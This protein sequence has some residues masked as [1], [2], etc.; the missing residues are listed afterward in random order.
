ME[1][2]TN[3]KGGRTLLNEGYIYFVDRESADKVIWRCRNKKSCRA[4]LHTLEGA[5]VKRLGEHTHA[6]SGADIEVV[7]VTSAIRQRAEST[8]D[9]PAQ[10]ITGSIGE[11][12]Q[13]ASA[14]L[15]SLDALRQK[16]KHVRHENIDTPPN[17]TSLQEIVVPPA[18][19]TT[20]NGKFFAKILLMFVLFRI[21]MLCRKISFILHYRSR[22]PVARFWRGRRQPHFSFRFARR[23]AVVG[24]V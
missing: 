10:I 21:E 1:I 20:A 9:A 6:P 4:R 13:P 8:H 19:R 14:I 23:L 18:L 17:P 2:T 16:I 5:I 7:R 15:P 12:S 22:L 3:Q 24:Y 11:L